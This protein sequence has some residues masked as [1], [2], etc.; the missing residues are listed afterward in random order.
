MK[1]RDRKSTDK[2]EDN[3]PDIETLIRYKKRGIPLSTAQEALLME[4]GRDNVR[5]HL[6]IHVTV[7]QAVSEYLQSTTAGNMAVKDAYY[8]EL[9]EYLYKLG[10]SQL[11]NGHALSLIAPDPI[12]QDWIKIGKYRLEV[13]RAPEKTR[14][15]A[16]KP[17][18]HL[19]P[20]LDEFINNRMAMRSA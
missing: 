8:S 3:T 19:N 15:A 14:G 6:E 11:S 13:M 20:G 17:K 10:S 16:Q 4:S 5:T 18:A 12:P 2:S 9:L 1:F 7:R